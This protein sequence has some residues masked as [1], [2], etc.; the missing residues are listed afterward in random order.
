MT[1]Y[2]TDESDPIVRVWRNAFPTLFAP[3]SQ[4]PT[5][6]QAHFRYPE[7]LFEVQA[8]QWTNYHVTNPTIFYQKQDFWQIPPD[9]TTKANAESRG[10]TLAPSEPMRPYYVLMR[11]PGDTDE[12]FVLIMPFTPQGRQNMVAWMAARS[13]VGNGYGQLVSYE[14]PSGQN[15]DGPSQVFSRIQQDATWSQ[16]QSLLS[17]GNSRVFYGDFLV[18]PVSGGLLYVEPVY[19]QSQ[20]E[21]P[22]PELKRVLVVSGGTVGLGSTLRDALSAA[23]AGSVPVEPGGGGGGGGGPT[24]PSGTVAQ[25]IATLLSEAQRHFDAADQALKSG[26]LALYQSEINAA[27][28]AIGLANDLAGQSGGSAASPSPSVSPTPSG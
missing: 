24:P 9:P 4:A 23:I 11:L 6:L 25:Q 10:E 1:Y 3:M 21:N 26:D 13:D 19:V 2:V 27:E 18:V 15:V 20:Q 28:H 14:F 16:Q 7:N 22:I 5:E 17:Q 8:T 12:S